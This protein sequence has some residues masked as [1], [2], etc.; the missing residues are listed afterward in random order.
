M[1]SPAAA[2]GQGELRRTVVAWAGGGS[3]SL[4]AEP[5]EPPP[6]TCMHTYTMFNDHFFH[7]PVLVN[8]YVC[9]CRVLLGF[10]GAEL[11]LERGESPSPQLC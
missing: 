11:C 4:P 6:D 1:E 2:P 10:C 7:T 5:P 8:W 3:G 9:G